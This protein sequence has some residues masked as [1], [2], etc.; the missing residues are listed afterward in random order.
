MYEC[1]GIDYSSTKRE[2]RSVNGMDHF[3]K[4]A[5]L[6]SIPLTLALVYGRP[7]D[8]GGKGQCYQ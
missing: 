8:T 1:K 5:N 3:T 2:L 7:K 6:I 4:Y